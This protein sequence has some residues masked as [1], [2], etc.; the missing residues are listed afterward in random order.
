MQRSRGL[1][2]GGDREAWDD[3]EANRPQVRIDIPDLAVS[4]DLE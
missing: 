3:L 1:G 2:G 4:G